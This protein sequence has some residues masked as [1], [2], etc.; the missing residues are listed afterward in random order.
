MSIIEIP[1]TRSRTTVA[2]TCDDDLRPQEE[3]RVRAIIRRLMRP[4]KEGDLQIRAL[5]VNLR[6]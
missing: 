1:Y 4:E 5:P 2:I 3:E 6:Y